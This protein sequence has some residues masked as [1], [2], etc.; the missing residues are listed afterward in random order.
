M[1]FI[2]LTP[3]RTVVLVDFGLGRLGTSDFLRLAEEAA[4]HHLDYSFEMV[5]AKAF[6][7]G[8]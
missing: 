1:L 3:V 8:L 4:A 2:S 5:I 6:V 7:I